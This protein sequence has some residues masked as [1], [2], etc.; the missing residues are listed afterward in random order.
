MKTDLKRVVKM[1]KLLGI[2]FEQTVVDGYP[3]GNYF[4]KVRTTTM[5]DSIHIGNGDSYALDWT[6]DKHGHFSQICIEPGYDYV[7]KRMKK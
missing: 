7:D 5:D 2:E 6:F 3:E 1:M 4:I